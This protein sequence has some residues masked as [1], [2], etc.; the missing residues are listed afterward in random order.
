MIAVAKIE[1]RKRERENEGRG[2]DRDGD[3]RIGYAAL[4]SLP[5]GFPYFAADRPGS[6]GRTLRFSRHAPLLVRNFHASSSLDVSLLSGGAPRRSES[7]RTGEREKERENVHGKRHE[8]E[9]RRERK[10][11]RSPFDTHTHTYIAPWRRA[12]ETSPTTTTTLI[13]LLLRT[14]RL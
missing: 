4:I 9:R 1:E 6:P 11:R 13:S 12:R 2:G 7:A 3:T 14:E 8:T 5:A 10:R